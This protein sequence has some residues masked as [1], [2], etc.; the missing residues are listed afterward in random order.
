MPVF[1]DWDAV[2]QVCQELAPA[3]ASIEGIR[4]VTVLL[5]DDGSTSN[6]D[7]KALALAAA[8]LPEVQIL[9]LRRNLGHQKAI[10]V[11]LAFLCEKVQPDAVLVMDA[12][13]EDRPQDAAQLVRAFQTAGGARVVFAERRKRLEGPTFR[14]LYALYRLFHW[15]MT[16]RRVRFGNFSIIPRFGV[17]SLV[18]V[19][20]LW[21]HYAAA[22]VKARLPFSTIPTNRGVRLSGHSH[23]DFVALVTHGLGAIAV[24]RELVGTRLLL[25]LA[26]AF[27]AAILV[28][29]MTLLS[30]MHYDAFSWALRAELLL[31]FF[32]QIVGSWLALAFG[33]LSI[34]D[35]GSVL[36]IRDYNYYVRGCDRVV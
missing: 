2:G 10:A 9:R 20:E 6:A 7:R 1:N 19:P 25:G 17:E 16:G 23:M 3:M 24:F 36:P 4:I 11:G 12:D 26:T 33:V 13:G 8:G 30:N 21:T 34:R 32:L 14:T 22:A 28:L 27:G 31:I 29:T 35:G 18:V 15:I 5:V